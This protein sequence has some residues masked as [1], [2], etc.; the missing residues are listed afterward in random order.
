MRKREEKAK[1]KLKAQK[2]YE[3]LKENRTGKEVESSKN[4]QGP[5]EFKEFKLRTAGIKRY[6]TTLDKDKLL[7]AKTVTPKKKA[8]TLTL[9]TKSFSA[10][11]ANQQD[12][13]SL[14]SQMDAFYHEETL[15]S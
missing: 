1:Q 5:T 12:F 13:I 9:S 4:R 7:A 8:N 14:K 11:Q 15:C 6:S 10:K 3:K 2:Y